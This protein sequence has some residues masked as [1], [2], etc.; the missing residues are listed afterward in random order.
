MLRF[1]PSVLLISLVA[2]AQTHQHTASEDAQVD[3][4]RLPA[5]ER[6]E[7]IGQSHI[8][9]STKSPEAQQWFDQGLAL[10]HC[11]WDYEALRSFEQ[12]ARLDPDCALCHWGLSQALD[13]GSNNH[14]QAKEELKKAKE[15]SEHASDR[16]QRY[17]RAYSDQAEKQGD[18][19]EKVF[20]REMEALIAR[21][22]DDIQAKLLLASQLI[23]GYDSKGD[24][25]PGALYGQ[26]ILRNLLQEYPMN[27]AANH[28]WI[29]VVEPSDHPEWALGA[30]RSWD[31]LP[32]H[33][34]TW[35]TCRATFSS[36]WATTNA[37][38]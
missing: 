22:P 8:T 7:G 5:P 27:A 37:P 28:Y 30:R 6:I 16:E 14:E 29:H 11:F 10:L 38:A 24:P 13:F 31:S 26:A 3:L 18:E 17:I 23:N 9:I 20:T 25:R 35:C 32:L 2:L 1:L 33:P 15:L 4:V 36:A 19:A 12:A 21:Y 34:V